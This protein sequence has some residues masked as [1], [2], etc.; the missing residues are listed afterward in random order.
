MKF[1]P[2]CFYLVALGAGL[3]GA[4]FIPTLSLFLANELQVA[5]WKI[6]TFYSINAFTNIAISFLLAHFSD[7]VL[8]R[9]PLLLICLVALALNALLFIF[10]RSYLLLITLGSLLGAIGSAAA[11]Q[12]F[13]LARHNRSDANFSATLRAQF[14]LAWIFGP[15]LAFWLIDLAGYVWLYSVQLTLLL[16]VTLLAFRLPSGKQQPVQQTQAGIGSLPLGYNLTFLMLATLLVWSCSALYLI[17]FPLYLAQQPTLSSNWTGLLFGVAAA[18]EVPAMLLSA[19]LLSRWG[20]RAQMQVAILCGILF[21]LGLFF[22]R[23]LTSLL[24]LQFFN[25]V[26]IAVIAT[27]GLFWFQD[28]LQNRQGMAA[29]LYTNAVSM[30][31]LIA[32]GLQ[33]GLASFV[34]WP[35]ACLLL[36]LSFLLI[37]KVDNV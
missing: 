32:G 8:H 10:C 31:V 29:T 18:L 11:P 26:F 35:V 19:R 9:R 27:V 3:S 13:A 30:G 1:S 20:K 36:V 25:A 21:Y 34:I 14:S 37:A 4:L 2:Y 12:L 28:L 24:L 5:S 15:P 17:A 6:G 16:A 7:R 23:D 22:S 33:G